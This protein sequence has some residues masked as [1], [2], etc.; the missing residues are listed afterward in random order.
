MKHIS[1]GFTSVEMRYSTLHEQRP[2]AVDTVDG[3]NP[4]PPRMMIVPL[5][6]EQYYWKYF[7]ANTIIILHVNIP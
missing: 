5:F 2:A 3:Q 7:T 1:D 4:A 6:T